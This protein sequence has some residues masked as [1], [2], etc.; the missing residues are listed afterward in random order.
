MN[1]HS[2]LASPHVQTP[3]WGHRLALQSLCSCTAEASRRLSLHTKEP[4]IFIPK[5]PGADRQ[6]K[7]PNG[8]I[9]NPQSPEP[10]GE[11][12]IPSFVV[13]HRPTSSSCPRLLSPSR[14]GCHLRED[15]SPGPPTLRPERN[16]GGPPQWQHGFEASLGGF[17]RGRNTRTVQRELGWRPHVSP[18][19]KEILSGECGD[20]ARRPWH[21]AP[22]PPPAQRHPGWQRPGPA[23]RPTAAGPFR[24]RRP[25]RAAR[26]P[27]PLSPAAPLPGPGPAA[28]LREPGRLRV[29]SSG[30]GVWSAP[31][32]RGG[33][34]SGRRS[35]SAR[36][37]PRGRGP[38][39]LS[40]CPT[41]A[42]R[43]QGTHPKARPPVPLRGPRAARK[44]SRLT[45]VLA[46]IPPSKMAAPAPA[47]ERLSGGPGR[48]ALH[49][50]L[51][52]PT[53]AATSSASARAR[54]GVDFKLGSGIHRSGLNSG[55]T[56]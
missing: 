23:L 50:V 42:P 35:H 34:G 37:Q 52:L 38:G 28:Y 39:Q 8:I 46:L 1:E 36:P 56:S 49:S 17:S 14:K 24:Q 9:S 31:P 6:Y 22:G 45:L 5:H 43:P 2:R 20:S 4:W 10:Q 44:P 16:D 40:H 12:P 33:W 18:K 53:C 51:L 3:L 30:G 11:A 27:G 13:G 41:R 21:R 26:E 48:R 47:L 25:S 29:Q 32:P 7:H 15:A 54:L 55:P 19:H